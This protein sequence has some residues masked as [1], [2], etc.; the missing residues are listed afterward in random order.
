MPVIRNVMQ[1]MHIKT[2]TALNG[3]TPLK[4]QACGNHFN[5]ALQQ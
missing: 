4:V 5:N 1:T 2:S 3:L